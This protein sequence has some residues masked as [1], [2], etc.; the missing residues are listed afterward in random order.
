MDSSRSLTN[1]APDMPRDDFF[2]DRGPEP[3]AARRRRI[4]R[5]HPGITALFGHDWRSKYL[6]LFLLVIPP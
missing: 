3:H 5:A 2:W 6:C 1:R 4:L